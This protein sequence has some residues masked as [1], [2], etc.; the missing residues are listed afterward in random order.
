[1]LPL[2]FINSLCFSFEAVILLICMN[3]FYPSAGHVL[4][5]FFSA[6]FTTLL[7]ISP[8]F[9]SLPFI[10][11]FFTSLLFLAHVVRVYIL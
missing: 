10:S 5:V 11:P 3:L 8:S 9:T 4:L 6:C 2:E 1:M 7:F